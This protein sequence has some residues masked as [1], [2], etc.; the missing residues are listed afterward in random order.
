MITIQSVD[1]A[2]KNIYLESVINDINTKTNPFLTM[3]QK[4]SKTVSGKEA[5]ALIRFGNLGSVSAGH[6]GGELPV[7]QGMSAEIV[8]TLKN[9]YGTFQIS[10]KAIRSAQNSPGAFSS[11]IS[12]E[13][14]NLVGTAQ[15]NLN[16]MLYGNGMRYLGHTLTVEASAVTVPAR[17]IGNFATGQRFRILTA[18]NAVLGTVTA[19]AITSTGNTHRVAFSGAFTNVN[20]DR[21]YLFADEDNIE[22]SGIDRIFRHDTLYNL[23]I[24]T[25][26]EIL[27]CIVT[28]TVTGTQQV[29][30]EAEIMRFFTAYEEHNQSM[31]A[32]ILLTHPNVRRAIFEEL[33][34]LRTNVDA[35]E[36]AGGF[37]GF[38][39]NGLP[40][41]S[42]MKCRPGTMYALNS[43]SWGMH[44]LCDWTWLSGDDGGVL[45]QIDGKAGYN[46]TLVKYADLLCDKPFLQ[47]KVT[48][49]SANRF[50]N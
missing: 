50:T 28:D 49:F 27:P 9:L 1:S 26:R 48:N 20:H 39:F 44:Q 14:L 17:Y 31:P 21:Y 8:T 43:D 10:D 36:L 30:N 22:L 25:N 45:K 46:A 29:L 19:G 35:A 24:A 41:Y 11:L 15:R 5:R 33:K 18:N 23:P 16:G 42:D 2:L 6:E 12:N 37:K 40:V 47:G 4:N 32:D 3:V 38:T 7:N 13:M 34:N